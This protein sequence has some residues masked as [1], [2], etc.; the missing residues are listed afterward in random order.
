M[1]GQHMMVLI[2]RATPKCGSLLCLSLIALVVAGCAG[3]PPPVR[4]SEPAKPAP[5]EPTAPSPTTQPAETPAA[6]RNEEITPE[7]SRPKDVDV[8]D[9]GGERGPLTLVEAAR[10]ERER[11]ARSGPPVAV[12]TDK[13]VAHSTGRLTVADP[14]KPAA[15]GADAAAL[16]TI[17]DEQY[18]RSRALDIRTRLRQATDRVEDLELSAAGWRRRFYAEE[19]PYFRDGKIKPEWDRVLAQLEETRNE[20][21]TTRKE[22]E[23]FLDE[24]RRAGAMPGWLREGGELEPEEEK[25]KTSPG[26]VDPEEPQIYE[27]KPPPSLQENEDAA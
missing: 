4:R 17:K 24:G 10:A 26:I 27:Q 11:R 21:G 9:P 25:P 16:Q 7:S 18:W 23:D 1:K 8:V 12:I 15:T 2:R 6:S 13:N 3:A 20:V 14:K 19:D 5:A 22:L